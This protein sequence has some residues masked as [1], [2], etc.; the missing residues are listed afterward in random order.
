MNTTKIT[1]DFK[2]ILT[3]IGICLTILSLI[4]LYNVYF[5]L[6]YFDSEFT[7]NS[8]LIF[9][10]GISSLTLRGLIFRYR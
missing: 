9:L 10:I 1:S 4:R 7:K 6:M 3:I 5:G 2:I 8:W